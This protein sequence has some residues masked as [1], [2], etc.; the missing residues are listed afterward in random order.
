MGRLRIGARSISTRWFINSLSVV[1]ILLAIIDVGV[2]FFAKSYYYSAASQYLSAQANIVSGV[3][4]QLY[5]SSEASY[6]LAVKTAV[7]EFDKK[8]IIELMAVDKYGRV[9]ISSSGFAAEAVDEMPDYELAR[10]SK[11]G[12]AITQLSLNR[13]SSSEKCLAACVMLNKTSS[14]YSAIRMVTSLEKID[15]QVFNIAFFGGVFSVGI[16]LLLLLM[17]VYFIK[18]IVQPIRQ[19]ADSARSLAKGDFSSRIT[20]KTEDEIGEL[21]RVFNYMADE[22]ENSETIKNEFISSVSHELRTPLTA[23]KGWAETIVELRDDETISKGMRVISEE[24][25][26]LSEMVE[27]LLDFSRIQNNSLMLQKANMDVL[28]ELADAILIY[29][30]RARQNGIEIRYDEPDA[31]AMIYGDKNRIRQVFINIIDNAIKYSKAQGS[32]EIETELSDGKITITIEDSGVGISAEDLPKI[33]TRFYKANNTVRGSGIGLAVADEIIRM[34]EG[35]IDISSVQGKGTAVTIVLPILQK[36][37]DE[38]EQRK[39]NELE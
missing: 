5:E 13:G 36:K 11:N 38:P 37:A 9:D 14:G 24:T 3:L 23:I 4:N 29:G 35:R 18:S 21:C 26:R 8:E 39:D 19:I 30:E 33:K 2:Y 17:G 28:A 31:V 16:I 7:E 6:D 15:R 20:P 10:A 34:H 12:E 25:E 1:V 22:L 27:E 32:I